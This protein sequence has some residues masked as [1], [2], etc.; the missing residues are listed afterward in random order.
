M[1]RPPLTTVVVRPATALAARPRLLGALA[2]A[3]AV[4]FVAEGSAEGVLAFGGAASGRPDLPTLRLCA[5]AAPG[6]GTEDVRLCGDGRPRPAP[7]RRRARR[8]ARLPATGRA[9]RGARTRRRGAALAARRAGRARGRRAA[10]ARTRADAP[11]R[12][13]SRAHRGRPVRA[14]AH[15][16]RPGAGARDDPL[17]RPE[18]ALAQLRLHRLRAPGRPCRDARLPRRDGDDPARHAASQ[19]RDGRAVPP[20]R[21]PSVA[22]RARQRPRLPR[23]PAHRRTRRGAR[24][25]GAGAAARRA[26]RGTHGRRGRAG[27]DATARH[28]LGGDGRGAR[29]ARVRRAVR[30][31]PAAVD[32]APAGRPPSRRLGTRPTSRAPA[33]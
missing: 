15:G 2:E 33:P 4:R 28:V 29:R 30:D 16:P 5:D 31:P 13:R 6:P 17:R 1:G 19:R 12:A 3:L 9:R 22:R 7:A 18:P 27:H 23:A 21:R 24:A 10:R 11:R 32:R 26:L 20:A 25:G 14:R 8:P